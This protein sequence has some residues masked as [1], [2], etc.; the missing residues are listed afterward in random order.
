MNYHVGITMSINYQLFIY[1]PIPIPKGKE[2]KAS[3][4]TQATTALK[5]ILRNH[6]QN[7]LEIID[8]TLAPMHKLP[9]V[10]LGK[11]ATPI[12]ILDSGTTRGYTTRV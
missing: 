10:I 8:K 5:A 12:L 6:F 7:C 3:R 2:N 11:Q 1:H 4:A 9:R